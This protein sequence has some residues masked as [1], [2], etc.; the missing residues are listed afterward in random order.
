[1]ATL[2]TE[3]LRGLHPPLE[4]LRLNSVSIST[5]TAPSEN[6]TLDCSRLVSRICLRHLHLPSGPERSLS[7]KAVLGQLPSLGGGRRE[8]PEITGS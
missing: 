5:V 8:Y 7:H 2:A 4:E 3:S 6:D 1:M